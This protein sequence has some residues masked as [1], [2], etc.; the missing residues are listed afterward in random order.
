MAQCAQSWR[1][2]W[3]SFKLGHTGYSECPGQTTVATA[4]T[5]FMAVELII[6]RVGFYILRRVCWAEK[7]V[8]EQE[9]KRL[10]VCVGDLRD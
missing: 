8:G 7:S 4:S 3:P 5:H 1:E 2:V 9:E 6:A 10:V